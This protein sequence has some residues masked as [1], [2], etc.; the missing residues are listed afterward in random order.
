M[1]AQAAL[2]QWIVDDADAVGEQLLAHLVAQKAGLARDRSAIGGAGEVRNQRAGH[3]AVEHHRHFAGGYLSWVEPL[4][5][6]LAGG[7]A[8]LLR[9]LQI[10]GVQHR[11]MIVVAL[12]AGAF[13]GDRGHRQ[14][15]ARA[16]IG[17][18]KTVAGDQH[19]AADAGRCRGA[20]RLSDALD[21]EP[22][23]FGGARAIATAR[24]ASAALPSLAMSLVDT[25]AWRFP[26]S[27]RRPRSSP[28]ARSLSSTAPSRTSIASDI[29]RNATASA[30]SAPRASAALTSRSARSVRAVWSNKDEAGA[31]MVR[32]SY[33]IC[34]SG[35]RALAREPGIQK[36][37]PCLR[38]DSGSARCARVPE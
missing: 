29:P 20:A 19:H 25:T 21:R 8:D 33:L 27:T 9:R 10:G 14:A 30:A 34:H 26:T 23:D 16:Q 35:A 17:A 32:L 13:T 31:C 2:A 3:S 18:A 1:R 37:M 38:L 22:G 28:S 24:S 15:V 6:A 36:Q 5:R 11:G 12:H 7:A 4:E